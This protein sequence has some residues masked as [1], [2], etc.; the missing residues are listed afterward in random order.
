[1]KTRQR[2][3]SQLHREINMHLL[4]IP[5]SIWYSHLRQT[6]GAVSKMIKVDPDLHISIIVPLNRVEKV[7]W[8]LHLNWTVQ[9]WPQIKTKSS[10]AWFMNT[11]EDHIPSSI[12]VISLPPSFN[13][14]EI[15]KTWDMDD[16]KAMCER[17]VLPLYERVALGMNGAPPVDFALADPALEV[18]L[19]RM[20]EVRPGETSCHYDILYK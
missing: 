2:K 20:K 8:T 5:G 18:P 16:L 13:T 7:I 17:D 10:L 11:D 1:M 3:T 14:D 6:C 15:E 12:H 4:L 9:N 19:M